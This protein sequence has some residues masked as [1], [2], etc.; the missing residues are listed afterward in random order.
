MVDDSHAVGFLV[1]HGRGTPEYH[2]VTR[3]RSTSS[4]ARWA[5]PWAAAAA[6][7]RA[8]AR[9]IVELL[10]QRS[11]PYLFSNSLPPPIVAASL[12]SLEMLTPLDRAARPAGAEHG[13][14]PRGDEPRPGSRSCPACIRSCPSCWA[15]PCWPRG[16]PRCC[17][18]EGVYVI[19]FLLSGR[20][21]GQ[22][23]H[24]HAGFRGAFAGRFGVCGRCLQGGQAGDGL[25]RLFDGLRHERLACSAVPCRH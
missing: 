9:E 13:L 25:L 4:P 7:T 23:P 19:G 21:A 8:P 1:P 24:S 3:A 14:V 16:W 15:T 12:K 5:R 6:A 22:G 18:A 17:L 10:R 2:G 11:R 20:A